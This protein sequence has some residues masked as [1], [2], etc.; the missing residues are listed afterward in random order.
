MT[1]R[2]VR[3][4]RNMSYATGGVDVVLKSILR[5]VQFGTYLDVGANHP[6]D[7][8]NT[9][10]FYENGWSGFAID[11]NAEYIQT[12]ND[13]RPRD[14]FLNEV[15]SD[16][17]KNI[18]FEIF[19]EPTMSTIDVS[20]RD[21]YRKKFENNSN[22]IIEMESTTIFDIYEESIKKEI[23]LL[24]ID[25]EG[26]EM[27]ALMGANLSVFR[28]GVICIEIKNLSVHNLGGNDIFNYLVEHGYR[29]ITKTPLDSIFVDLDKSYLSWVP[30]GIA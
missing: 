25:I 30:P 9:Y 8:S 19:P 23:H 29:M 20:T 21:R 15:V 5:D 22:S 14:I 27:N 7:L 4:E 26:E 18:K 6:I 17:Q 24:N 1:A 16:V 13:L 28:P 12:W 11:G 2:L 3:P 10:L